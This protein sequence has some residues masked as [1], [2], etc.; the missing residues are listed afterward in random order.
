[1]PTTARDDS[2]QCQKQGATLWLPIYMAKTLALEPI[3]SVPH[4]QEVK[5]ETEAEAS[6]IPWIAICNENVL[7]INL[8]CCT[9]MRVPHGTRWH[10]LYPDHFT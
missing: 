3:G 8:T 9:M 10:S 1:M 4:W 5:F 7:P 6:L 2:G